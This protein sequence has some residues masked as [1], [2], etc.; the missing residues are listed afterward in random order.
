M[1]ITENLIDLR[2]IELV[3][4]SNVMELS[5][6]NATISFLTFANFIM[7]AIYKVIFGSIVPRISENLK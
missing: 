5:E 1:V 2:Q 7:L 3:N 6:R 4:F